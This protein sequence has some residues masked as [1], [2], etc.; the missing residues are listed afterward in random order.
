MSEDTTVVVEARSPLSQYQETCGIM[1]IWGDAQTG[2]STGF[3][4]KQQDDHL[5]QIWAIVLSDLMFYEVDPWLEPIIHFSWVAAA[6]HFLLKPYVA[7]HNWYFCHLFIMSLALKNLIH[8]LF[9]VKST[10]LSDPVQS[11]WEKRITPPSLSKES[12]PSSHASVGFI[13]VCLPICLSFKG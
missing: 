13:N 2:W 3:N 12:C 10:H 8:F 9:G 5:S 11:L 7:L 4:I 1:A 6:G